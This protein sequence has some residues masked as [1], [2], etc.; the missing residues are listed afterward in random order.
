MLCNVKNALL[1]HDLLTPVNGSMIL[2]LQECL[3]KIKSSQ[4]IFNLQYL[5]SVCLYEWRNHKSS[6]LNENGVKNQAPRL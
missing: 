5:S 1:E 2:P 4:K 3:A 6:L